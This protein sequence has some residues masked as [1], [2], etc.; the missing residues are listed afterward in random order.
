MLRQSQIGCSA[1]KEVVLPQVVN[2]SVG[3]LINTEIVTHSLK[4]GNSVLLFVVEQLHARTIF[5]SIDNLTGVKRNPRCR[6]VSNEHGT[7][8][9]G[10]IE[11]G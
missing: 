7:V 11:Q 3:Q 9:I 6:I 2:G 5:V 4:S 10:I 1:K 8:Q